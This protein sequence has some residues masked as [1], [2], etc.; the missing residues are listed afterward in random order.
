M[1]A[2]GLRAQRRGRL[3]IVALGPTAG[4]TAGG[5]TNL[6]T[7]TWN[8]WLFGGLVLM[9]SLV[10]ASTLIALPRGNPPDP[11]A[12]PAE[13]QQPGSVLQP[14]SGTRVFIGRS[15]ELGR[16]AAPTP[17]GDRP[18]PLI[19]VITGMPGTGKTELAICA[20]RAL[21]ARYP[22]GVFWLGLRTYAATES[23]LTSTAALRTL[24]NALNVPPDPNATS[25]TALN[26]IWRA[27]TTSK[28]LS[29]ATP[30]AW[31]RDP[32]PKRRSPWCPRLTSASE[33]PAH[34]GDPRS[35][36]RR[37]RGWHRPGCD[38]RPPLRDARVG[39]ALS[40]LA[41]GQ[42]PIRAAPRCG[43]APPP[44]RTRARA[45][46]EYRWAQPPA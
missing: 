19:L 40:A 27:A 46:P 38:T 22:D 4:V 44:C 14:P 12:S 42:D 17:E 37:Q 23:Q 33:P 8:W 28:K 29:R 21:A 41:A 24:L 25:V 31:C 26:R 9:T 30:F 36:L 16:L 39:W 43:A 34:G 3:V 15:K 1:M 11:A 2:G 7:T 5:L 35:A 13:D 32:P 20:T 6:L 18:G 45:W 10:S